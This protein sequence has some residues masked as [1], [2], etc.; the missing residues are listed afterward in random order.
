M[1]RIHHF[2]VIALPVIWLL[3]L[4]CSNTR[5]IEG[6]AE[7]IKPNVIFILADDLGYGDLSCYGQQKFATPN[8]DRLAKSGML[9]TQHYSGATVCAPSRS[10]LLTGMHTG[11]TPIRGNYEVKPEG[12]YPLP[13]SVT[14]IAEVFKQAG[15]KTGAFGKWGLGH[16]GSEGTPANQGF[17]EFYGYNCQRLAH[18]YYPYYLWHNNEVDS[19]NANKGKLKGV[20]APEVIH[21]Q[22]LGFLE[23]NKDNPFFMF[24]P[25]AI[26]HAEMIAPDSV[27]D[28]HRGK[29]MPEKAYKGVDDGLEY[30]K[31]P[32][33][34]QSESHAAFVAMVEILDRQVGEI[35]TKVRQLGIEDRTMIIFTSDN[36]PHQEAG[37]DPKYFNSNGP[38]KGFKRDL[39]EGGI[40][41]PLIAS[42]PGKIKKGS[43]SDHIS[44]FW[45]FL[46]TFADLADLKGIAGENNIDGISM[47][48]TLLNEGGQKAHDYLYWEF[49]EKGGRQAVRQGKWKAVRY[50]VFKDRNST[51]ELYDLSQDA[52]EENNLAAQYPEITKQMAGLMATS[53]TESAVFNFKNKTY[54]NSK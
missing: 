31:G 25:S 1:L 2:A 39:Y 38:L 7:V 16:P 50:H 20:Y 35:M 48:P 54:L 14:T 41:V 11:H 6:E 28:K 15:Y 53:R 23:K 46:P 5:T 22:A 44:A 17:D 42:W 29:Y 21:E 18:H 37:A 9:F 30:R 52:G 10:A 13:D 27:M 43:T 4:G 33:E 45:D 8:I 32:Y 26:P 49:H 12:Q 19:L 40:R 3:I 51:P 47:A 24:Y 34:S 36:G